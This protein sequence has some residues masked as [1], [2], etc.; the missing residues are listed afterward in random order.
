MTEHPLP[1]FGLALGEAARKIGKLHRRALAEAG[2][3]F[4]SWMLLVLLKEKV[5]ALAV[6]EV[7]AELDRRMDLAR[8]AVINL[9]ERTAELGFVAYHPENPTPMVA[10]TEA[11]AAHFESMY[12]YARKATD[13]AIGGID[14]EMVETAIRV[15]LEVD[16]RAASL[17]SA[18]F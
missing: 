7:V 16:K 10:L 5:T 15:L 9:L 8:P 1:S 14:P 13:A 18:P 2:S 11:G 4:P 6:D 3:D 17:M 12:A